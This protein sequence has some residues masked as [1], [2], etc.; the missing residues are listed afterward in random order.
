[1]QMGTVAR[2]ARRAAFVLIPLYVLFLG[3]MFV[4]MRQPPDRF[5]QVMKHVPMPAMMVLPFES[6]WNVARGGTLDV[7][8]VAPDFSLPLSDHSG[9]VQL[10][11]F[12]GR[13]PVVL[14]FGS[15]T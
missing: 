3:V 2:V 12:R 1:M 10:S 15:Y 6:L 9:H 8:E 14:V 13:Q 4:V 7:G 11:S 5:G